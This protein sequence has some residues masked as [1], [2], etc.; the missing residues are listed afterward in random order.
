[1]AAP[2]PAPAPPVRK[3]ARTR[4]QEFRSVF[5]DLPTPFLDSPSLPP[6]SFAVGLRSHQCPATAVAACSIHPRNS[7]T[8]DQTR[9]RRGEE[10]KTCMLLLSERRTLPAISCMNKPHAVIGSRDRQIEAVYRDLRVLNTVRTRT[11]ERTQF[12]FIF[13]SS[14]V[15]LNLSKLNPF[16]VPLF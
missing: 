13:K 1:M 8:R 5:L 9:Q 6:I 14:N 16:S 12:F 11:T 3:H 2:A 15:N 4:R 10:D 7:G